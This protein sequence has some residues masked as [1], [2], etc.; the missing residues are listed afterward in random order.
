MIIVYAP[1][2]GEREH[3]DAR[4]LRVSEASIVSRTTDMKWAEVQQSLQ[5]DD[6]EAMR[7]VAWVIKKRGN[8]SLRW[9]DF[10]PGVEELYTRLDKDE[11]VG[12]VNAGIAVA[13]QNPDAM[14]ADIRAALSDLPSLAFDREHAERVIE[15][16][17]ADPKDET[18]PGPTTE[19]LSEPPSGTPTSTLSESSTSPSSPTSS[20]SHPETSTT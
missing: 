5:A 15:E 4:S 16:M 13:T 7:G 12:W 10:D 18:D 8:P 6:L 1:R 20:T 14:P 9:D 2:D 3:F 19:K 17:V 11:V